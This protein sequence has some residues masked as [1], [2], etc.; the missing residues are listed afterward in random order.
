LKKYISQ[1]L[2]ILGDDRRK[3]PVLLSLFL[4]AALLELVGI[5]LIGPYIS[6][7]VGP[8][9]LDAKV[10]V[11]LGELGL[12]DEQ[13]ALLMIFGYGLIVI[14]LLR[15]V[16]SILI[17]Y[18]VTEFSQ[19]QQVRLRSYLMHA[20]QS[21]S[22][23][24]YIQR[25]SSEYIDSIQRLA[26][27]FSYIVTWNILRT[28][29][30]GVVALAIIGVLA[31][32]NMMALAVL[33]SLFGGVLYLYD[34]L[35][36]YRLKYY[37]EQLNIASVDMLKGIHEGIDGLKE[38]RVLGCEQYFHSNVISSAKKYAY[39]Q[40]ISVLLSS[41]PRY[42]LELLLVISIVLLVVITLKIGQ[43]PISLLPTLGVF[44][45]A[46]MRLLPT[47]NTVS[48]TI[49][50]LRYTRDVVN[51]LY[52][53]LKY[54]E[55]MSH[56]TPQIVQ[57]N[58]FSDVDFKYI[59]ADCI[60]YHYP[61][62]G[63]NALSNLS[64]KIHAG[65]SI[66]LIGSSGSGKTT[67]VDTLLGLLEPQQGEIIFNGEP[68]KGA[69]TAWRS[70]VAYLPQQIFLIDNTLKRNIALGVVDEEIDKQRLK[71]ALDKALLAELVEQ[72]PEGVDTLLGERGVRL[73]GGQR[74]RVAMARAFYHKR[75]V[76][77]MDEAT[78]A[79][80]N[81]TEREIVEEIKRLKGKVTM[82]V[83]AHRLTTLQHCDRIYRIEKGEVV[84]TGT[85]QEMLKF[86]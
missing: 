45:V 67:L 46:A 9:V 13:H 55:G 43:E 82:I 40:K 65:E 24:E 41:I 68:L 21:L 44:G 80:D 37:G 59:E 57:P 2:Y 86:T 17:S 50:Q 74:Q 47:V 32:N 14:F 61:N 25:N 6:L 81:E 28:V 18:K 7:L 63:I 70:H 26:G 72:L 51:R 35:S 85:P 30:E 5:G 4:V 36:R 54:F 49:M 39:S 75:D 11:S 16:L 77:I 73:S 69:L 56:F 76:L 1:V 20:Y 3:V 48:T 38:V 15:A 71:S 58:N 52:G 78:S 29:G 66:G 8:Q 53:D 27:Q 64:L 33:A 34:R 62:V 31:W 12:P 84:E 23:T 42:L 22:Y 60:C 10:V 83:I 19:H 79:L